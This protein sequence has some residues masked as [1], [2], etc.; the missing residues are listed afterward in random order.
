MPSFFHA[1]RCAASEEFAIS[2]A[3]TL[4]V[5][6]WPMRWNTRS[7]PVRST[8]TS[9]PPNFSLN[10]A[11]I[12]SETERSIEGYQTT[13]PSF[14]AASIRAGVMASGGGASARTGDANTVPS[15]RA[16]EPLRMSRRESL[17]CFIASSL[18]LLLPAQRAAAVGRQRQ[19][20]V[21]AL[22]DVG[23]RRRG[24]PQRGA[25]GCFDH[26]V[27][28]HAEIDLPRHDGLDRI[29]GRNR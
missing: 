28:P 22:G 14:F 18:L 29:L 21:A 11:A 7:A 6:S 10:E 20:D 9:M 13:L 26:V 3:C 23:F 4:L 16:L 15:A 8:R 17:C 2:T 27:A 12:F 1:S 5:Y 24:N 19:P 25:I